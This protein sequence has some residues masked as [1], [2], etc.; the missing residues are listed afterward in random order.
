MVLLVL[1]RSGGTGILNVKTQRNMVY[2]LIGQLDPSMLLQ[3]V[4]PLGLNLAP[5][6]SHASWNAATATT[7]RRNLASW[8]MMVQSSQV[9]AAYLLSHRSLPGRRA[10][11]HARTEVFLT[12][13]WQATATTSLLVVSRRQWTVQVHPLLSS[14]PGCHW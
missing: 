2:Y 10:T 3:W 13:L 7:C 9:V 8:R 6:K 12:C 1:V 11:T 4:P 14:Q 5:L